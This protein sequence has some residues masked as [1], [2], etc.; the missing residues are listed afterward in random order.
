MDEARQLAARAAI[1]VARATRWAVPVQCHGLAGNIEFLLDMYQ[2]TEDRAFWAEAKSLAR[3][4]ETFRS[5]ERGML[6]WS[7]DLPMRYSPDYTI[8]YSGI[9]MC[10]LRLADPE[11]LPRQL[12]RAGFR[13]H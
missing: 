10:L 6:V 1:T 7:A 3:L 8:G 5:Q 11:R 2:A 12:S 13:V 4:L 9:A